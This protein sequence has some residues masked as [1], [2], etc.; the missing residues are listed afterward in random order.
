MQ[1]DL[2]EKDKKGYEINQIDE[3]ILTVKKLSKRLGAI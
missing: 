2:L 1:L 3:T